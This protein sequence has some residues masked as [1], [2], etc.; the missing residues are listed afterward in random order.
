MAYPPHHR[1]AGGGPRNGPRAENNCRQASRT[2]ARRI[3][4]A[5]FSVPLEPL[6][7]PHSCPNLPRTKRKGKSLRRRRFTGP[8]PITKAEEFRLVN[9]IEDRLH[10]RLLT[11]YSSSAA[12]PSGRVPPSGF[13]IS[14]RRDGSAR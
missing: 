14:I 11:I 3:A 9:R 6:I 12:I 1:N 13:G 2:P 5:N 4:P 10:N 7:P 8:K